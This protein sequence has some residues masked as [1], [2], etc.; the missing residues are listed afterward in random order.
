M[1]KMETYGQTD[2][3]LKRT[4]NED[5]FLVDSH[6]GFCLL[7]DG[8]GGEAA[9][10]IASSIFA[11]SVCETFS[12]S[13]NR[14]TLSA[15]E[16]VQMAFQ[17]ANSRIFDYAAKHSE[18]KGMGCTAEILMLSDDELVVGH[19]GDSRTY[20]F[21]NGKLR[22]LT[23]D[24]SLVQEKVEQGLITADEAKTHPLRNVI[25]RAV[26][27]SH[28]LSLDIIRIKLQDNDL[29]LICSDGLTDMV[30]DDKIHDVLATNT[31]SKEKAQILVDLALKAGGFDNITVVLCRIKN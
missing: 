16:L 27:I 15:S 19:I 12:Q 23:R 9:G 8:M 1:K 28:N 3:G 11:K 25:S 18:Y 4:S 5:V 10:E 30:S 31:D 14:L 24:H 22:Q 21:K 29:F 20:R 26:G 17:T 6:N 13:L 2:I 7:A